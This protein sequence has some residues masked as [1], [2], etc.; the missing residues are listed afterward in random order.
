[1]RIAV[2]FF[3]LFTA[4]CSS[5][6]GDDLGGK[7]LVAPG[8]YTF[9]TCVQLASSKTAILARQKILEELTKKAGNGLDGRLIS[10]TT[11]QPEYISNRGLLDSIRH[12]E[13]EKNCPMKP[14]QTS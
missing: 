7:L 3:A 8:T 5:S 6:N 13:A 10:A 14:N 2:F 1:M 12:T 9:Y 4:A 11:Y